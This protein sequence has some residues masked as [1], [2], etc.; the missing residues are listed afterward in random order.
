MS[1]VPVLSSL[2]GPLSLLRLSRSALGPLASLAQACGF[3]RCDP[4]A[5]LSKQSGS[6]AL[7]A[8]APLVP[9]LLGLLL[10]SLEPHLLALVL[11]P[12]LLRRL[13]TPLAPH[14]LELLLAA[15]AL[16]AAGPLEP[17]LPGLLLAPLEPHLLGLLLTSLEPH[18]LGLVLAPHLLG[19]LLMPLAPHLL[20]LLLEATALPAATPLA[21]HL[22]GMLLGPLAPHLLGLLLA[23]LAPHL[24]ELLLEPRVPR[25]LL[26][27]LLSA[28]P[29]TRGNADAP[30]RVL[31]VLGALPAHSWPAPL[32]F[33]STDGPPFPLLLVGVPC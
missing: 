5:E 17:D 25:S 3:A 11:A 1:A 8:A 6:A 27:P 28:A 19:R 32:S 13:L 31:D 10:T 15:R 18:L 23:P 33:V 9:H 24:P 21:P 20:E 12:H 14:L 26:G 4:A 22:Q 7:P 2:Q 16:P 30:R 29:A